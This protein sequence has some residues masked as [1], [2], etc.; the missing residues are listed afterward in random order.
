[1]DENEKINQQ[2]KYDMYG[3][4][5]ACLLMLI[6]VFGVSIKDAR[7]TNSEKVQTEL[8]NF[9]ASQPNYND[10]IR[11]YDAKNAEDIAHLKNILGFLSTNSMPRVNQDSL[12]QAFINFE[13]GRKNLVDAKTR[14]DSLLTAHL[15]SVRR[16]NKYNVLVR[17][18][19]MR[20]S[21]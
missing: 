17:N 11:A 4:I 6:V 8:N 21:K 9:K 16:A 18:S 15:D 3:R 12:N 2:L 19:A 5:I 10:S 13:T 7:K 1:M 20:Y 14:T